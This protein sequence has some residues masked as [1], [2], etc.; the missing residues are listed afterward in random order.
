MERDKE[1]PEQIAN[2][3]KHVLDIHAGNT[4]AK[5]DSLSNE[6]LWERT[7]QKETW[8]ELRY[9]KWKWI[10]HILRQD[11]ECIANKALEWNPQG[12]K[13]QDYMAKHS[14]DGSRSSRE[15]LAGNKQDPMANFHKGRMTLR[16]VKGHTHI[17]LPVKIST[18]FILLV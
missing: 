14:D 5:C 2:L 17:T 3:C 16:G 10:G 15:E 7:K 13:T 8:K 12:G 6:N 9:R 4:V 11:N 18:G 1:D